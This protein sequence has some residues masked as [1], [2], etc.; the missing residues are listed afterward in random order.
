[1][2]K[3]FENFSDAEFN[4]RGA[5]IQRHLEERG[6]DALVVTSINNL[7]YV[8]GDT[9]GYMTNSGATLGLTAALIADGKARIMVR[10]YETASARHLAPSWL[11]VVPYSGD[12]DDP[13]NPADVL[14]DLLEDAGL[15]SAR[16]GVE[17]EL[18]GLTPNDLAVLQRRLPNARFEDASSVVTACAVVKSEEELAVMAR[19]MRAT[20]AGVQAIA[21][22]LRPGV[23]EYELAAAV[24]DAMVRVGS[25]YPIFQPF[26]SSAE[27]SALPHA[28]WSDRTI[29]KGDT[30]FSELSGAILRYHAPLIRTYVVGSN[31]QA[32]EA[33]RVTEEALAA[34]LSRMRPGVSTGE[35]DD[36]CRS[37]IKKAGYGKMFLLRTGYQVGI[38]WVLRGSVSL[39][40]GS[41][42]QLVPGMTFHVRPLLQSP[43]RFSVGCSE[44]V[45]VTQTGIRA[46][47]TKERELIRR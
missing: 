46:L 32:E 8:A 11:T 17:L 15:Q 45:V 1:M 22:N 23:R 7:A 13:R 2:T 40:P 9:T 30:V 44:T 26:V 19:A 33:Y 41:R 35:V 29:A 47:S 14:A 3:P 37:V 34:A 42:D 16:V 38:D 39:M 5:L 31:T 10:I 43:A 12:A 25:G 21:E 20:E 27:R 36:A 24:F 28:V 6:L 18:P 4:R